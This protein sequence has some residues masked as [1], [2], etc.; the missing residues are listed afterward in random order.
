MS[1]AKYNKKRAFTVNTEGYVFRKLSEVYAENP[2][3][4]YIVAGAFINPKGKFGASPFLAV[5][6]PATGEGFFLNLP[7]GSLSIIEELMTDAET[8]EQINAGK[9][10]VKVVPYHSEKYDSDSF[11]PEFVDL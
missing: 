9:A 4:I 5:K 2:E 6:D 7:S 1:I 3:A 8:V 11:I 10:G